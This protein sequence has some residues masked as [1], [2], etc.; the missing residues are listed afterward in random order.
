MTALANDATTLAE[1]DLPT[2]ALVIDLE[3]AKRNIK[4]LA[5]YCAKH[6]LKFR[7]HT[8]THKSQ[9][10]AKL[11]LEGGANGLTVAKVGEAEVMAEVCDDLFLAYPALDPARTHR[12]A[13]IAQKITMRVGVD[14][15][16]AVDRLAEAARDEGSTIGVL[17]DYDVGMHRTGVQ[18]PD[19]ALALAQHIDKTEG[20]RFDGM[21]TYPGHVV[22]TPEEQAPIL[23]AIDERMKEVL[24][25]WK[26]HGL[27]AQI[28]TGGS[29]PTQE[30]SHNVT[31]LTEIRPGTSIF[32]DANF[33][34]GGYAEQ[35]DCAATIKVTVVSKAVPGK[36]VIDSGSKTL[37]S[38]LHFTK[39]PGYGRIVEYPEARIIKLSEEHGE[40][41]L[42][43]CPKQPNLGDRLTVIPNHICP[44][45]NLQ[46]HAWLRKGDGQL[47]KLKI[48]ARGLLS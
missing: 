5:D 17:A 24:E 18:T 12:L 39:Q 33:W 27:E 26:K 7:P 32:Y 47:Q 42:S 19:E 40:V 34:L 4:R 6:G 14:S 16:Y 41:D 28:V 46:T 9:L 2:P 22:G 15:T 44:V 38:D 23:K 29:T 21:M 43:N 20:V 13:K 1:T 8:K 11:Q 37:T 10:F 48:D 3:Q 30:Q 35:S 25:L 31:S 45:V 36:C